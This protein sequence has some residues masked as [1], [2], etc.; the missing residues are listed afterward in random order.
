[1]RHDQQAAFDHGC[2][3]CPNR[4]RFNRLVHPMRV[5]SQSDRPV[6][7]NGMT[8]QPGDFKFL[9]ECLQPPKD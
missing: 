1:M 2:K 4:A 6:Y 8:V 5:M 7:I 9:L 3:P